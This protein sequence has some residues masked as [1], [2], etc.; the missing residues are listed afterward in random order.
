MATLGE[1]IKKY[2]ISFDPKMS[3]RKF[4]EIS[5]LSYSYVAMLERNKDPRGNPIVPTIATIDKVAK[6]MDVE[7]DDLFRQLDPSTLVRVNATSEPPSFEQVDY[8]IDG[9]ILVEPKSNIDRR[10]EDLISLISQLSEEDQKMLMQYAQFLLS[11]E[12]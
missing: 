7:F 1:I 5:N 4:A 12:E 2:R 8:L 6:A 9:N 10:N 11:K 3:L